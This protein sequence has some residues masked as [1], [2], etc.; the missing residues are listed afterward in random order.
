MNK[1]LEKIH[2]GRDLQYIYLNNQNKALVIKNLLK[3]DL[4][5]SYTSISLALTYLY[6]V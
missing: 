2:G 6:L 4:I 1:F 5:S 3:I